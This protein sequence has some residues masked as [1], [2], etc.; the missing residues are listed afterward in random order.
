[1]TTLIYT[2]FSYFTFFLGC[3]NINY[4]DYYI[5]ATVRVMEITNGLP[6]QTWHCVGLNRQ[7]MESGQ[8]CV[9]LVTSRVTLKDG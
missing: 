7:K 5:W 1:M 6:E 4:F 2:F 8:D 9:P 3:T